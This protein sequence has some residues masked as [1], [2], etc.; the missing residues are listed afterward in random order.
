QRLY[1]ASDVDAAAGEIV[2]AKGTL[3][4]TMLL[5]PPGRSACATSAVMIAD[6]GATF[7]GAGRT[8]SDMT[9]SMNL[10]EWTRKRVFDEASG[11]ECRGE[12]TVSLRAG[13]EGEGNPR[14]S[15]EGRSFLLEQLHRLTPEHMRAVLTAARVDE[16]RSRSAKQPAATDAW[17]GAFQDKVR[18]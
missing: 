2:A 17:V 9:A 16:L 1:C 8:S 7:G 3:A 6:V 11:S 15:E 18:Q 10:E 4:R 5:E 12:L 14:V 13:Q